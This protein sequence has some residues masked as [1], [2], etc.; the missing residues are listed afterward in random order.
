M[1]LS[2]KGQYIGFRNPETGELREYSYNWVACLFLGWIYL[3]Y[4]GWWKI[5]VRWVA[6]Q[7]LWLALCYVMAQALMLAGLVVRPLI[8]LSGLLYTDGL[9]GD[10]FGILSYVGL[11][12]VGVWFVLH[13]PEMEVRD[14]FA[15]GFAPNSG[16]D[17][18]HLGASGILGASQFSS[19]EQVWR[20]PQG[21]DVAKGGPLGVSASPRVVSSAAIDDVAPVSAPASNAPRRPSVKM[22]V[23]V[24]GRLLDDGLRK[25]LV[26]AGWKAPGDFSVNEDGVVEI[27]RKRVHTGACVPVFDALGFDGEAVRSRIRGSMAGGAGRFSEKS[28]RFLVEW[29]VSKTGGLEE[30]LVR[31]L[32]QIDVRPIPQVLKSV[33]VPAPWVWNS[34]YV[35]VA[36][37]SLVLDASVVLDGTA[38]LVF[39]QLGFDGEDVCRRAAEEDEFEESVVEGSDAVLLRKE[40]FDGA[41]GYVVLSVSPL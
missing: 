33:R 15:S 26:E 8:V 24:V 4:K 39:D 19:Y 14:L 34:Q 23:P 30:V 27:E 13:V 3:G 29:S 22:A 10:D 38:S 41:H 31:P 25:V 35:Y 20:Q 6:A 12:V 36:D 40:R 21:G 11:T 18:Q 16:T 9:Y 17:W 5:I 28:D 7:V 1:A 37:G 2:D 32:E